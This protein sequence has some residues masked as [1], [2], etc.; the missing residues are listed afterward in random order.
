[1]LKSK[2]C[3]SWVGEEDESA[4]NGED[5]DGKEDEI[6]LEVAFLVMV[7]FYLC[8]DARKSCINGVLM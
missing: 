8:L 3:N 2:V 6:L 7:F 5:K 4:R 1:M